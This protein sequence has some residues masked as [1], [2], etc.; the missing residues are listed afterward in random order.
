MFSEK[1][2]TD[3]ITETENKWSLKKKLILF[4]LV[5]VIIIIIAAAVLFVFLFLKNKKEEEEDLP[6]WIYL[7]NAS[8]YLIA[9]FKIDGNEV[10]NTGLSNTSKLID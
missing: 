2:N 6:P 8:S 3:D 5:P 1:L 9:E 7:K 10:I 4:V